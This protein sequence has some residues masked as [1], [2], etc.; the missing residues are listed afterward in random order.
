[1]KKIISTI[2]V[3]AILLSISAC[4][5]NSPSNKSGDVRTFTDMAGRE[6]TIDGNVSS[7]AIS[8]VGCA[9]IFAMLDNCQG[10]VAYPKTSTSYAKF[11]EMFVDESKMV[12]LPKDDIS[13]EEVINS[14]ADVVFARIKDIDGIVDQLEKAG[15]VVVDVE[16]KDYN[17]MLQSVQLCADIL[18]TE[19]AK[20]R[21]EAFI[22]YGN[23]TLSAIETLVKENKE[24]VQATALAIRDTTD[25]RAYGP[26]RYAGKWIEM[27]GFTCPLETDDPEAFVN[28]TAEEIV[29]YD[30]DYIF[31]ALPGEAQ[32][33]VNDSKW[34]GLKAYDN[35]RIYNCPEC[36]N[37]WCNQGSESLLQLY[38]ACEILYPDKVNYAMENVVHDF[39]KD[40]YS[41]D[42]SSDE[43]ASMLN[44]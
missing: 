15:I 23:D 35:G 33:M 17:E 19:E 28:L 2:L 10:M 24:S 31:F 42:L 32:N 27:C 16:F 9:D 18:G 26:G 30:A 12:M 43:I 7:Y 21:A 40:F 44:R 25:Y 22:K 13:A 4:G 38:W 1:M 5:N 14:G 3:F 39:Y 36:F 11:V 20:K 8:W 29:R 37:T 41:I 34:V 6:I